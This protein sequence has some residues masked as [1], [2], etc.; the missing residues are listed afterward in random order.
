MAEPEPP[1]ESMDDER[2]AWSLSALAE[3]CATIDLSAFYLRGASSVDVLTKSAIEGE[4][5]RIRESLTVVTQRLDATPI[6]AP[7][8]PKES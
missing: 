8:E 3:A 6:C 5:A 7:V 2:L 1:S 4:V